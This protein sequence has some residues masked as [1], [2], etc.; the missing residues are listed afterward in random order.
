MFCGILR[1][2]IHLGTDCPKVMAATHFHEVFANGLLGLDLPI[3]YVHME[4][5]LTD[6]QEGT[7]VNLKDAEA[8]GGVRIGIGAE[9]HYLYRYVHPGIYSCSDS[10]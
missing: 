1:H 9:I 2:L 4:A 7:L 10:Y 5:M 8:E 6:G 3:G